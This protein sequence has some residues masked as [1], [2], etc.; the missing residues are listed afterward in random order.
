MTIE[1]RRA[2]HAAY[3]REWKRKN[4][5][6][7]QAYYRASITEERREIARERARK[8][9]RDHREYALHC[10]HERYH[11]TKKLKGRP[12]GKQHFNWKGA[13]VGYDALHAWVVRWRG[14]PQR[15]EHCGTTE[16][17]QYDWANVDHHY[18]R[19][20]KDWIR[21]CRS[22][23]RRHDYAKGLSRRGLNARR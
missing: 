4:P 14:R 1:E 13:E 11:S 8:W 9:Y 19:N 15:C 18:R 21:L 20:L 12:T 3:M 16:D 6:K 22:C 23:H 2:K 5:E 7:I 17:K 10:G